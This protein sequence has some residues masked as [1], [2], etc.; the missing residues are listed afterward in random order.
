[1][2]KVKCSGCN[3]GLVGESFVTFECP[4][5]SKTQI[6]RCDTCRKNGRAYTCPECGFV[7]P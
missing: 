3:I 2:A 4:N 7:G 1:M 5:C 6:V